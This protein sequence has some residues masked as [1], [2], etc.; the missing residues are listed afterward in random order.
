M[1]YL[2]KKNQK[3]DPQKV[4]RIKRKSTKLIVPRCSLSRLRL[5]LGWSLTNYARRSEATYSTWAVQ[6]EGGKIIYKWS[7]FR[8]LGVNLNLCILQWA[9]KTV[10][11]DTWLGTTSGRSWGALG[12][13]KGCGACQGTNVLAKLP[14]TWVKGKLTV[15]TTFGAGGGGAGALEVRPVV[16]LPCAELD[17]F[18][19]GSTGSA[20]RLVSRCLG[21]FAIDANRASEAATETSKTK[22]D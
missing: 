4:M 11:Q 2:A 13:G 21:G 12:G 17:V 20:G 1:N 19:G 5:S 3:S 10:R 7:P 16:K 8:R 18:R 6:M 22:A 15:F 14:H 9:S